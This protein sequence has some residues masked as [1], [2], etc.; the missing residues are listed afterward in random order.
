MDEP[1]SKRWGPR[2]WS[3]GEK[4][5]SSK[6]EGGPGRG[7]DSESKHWAEEVEGQGGTREVG[8]GRTLSSTSQMLLRE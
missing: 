2:G 5:R 1:G 7:G 3:S 4:L 6:P 8:L